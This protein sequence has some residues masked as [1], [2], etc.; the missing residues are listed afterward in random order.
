MSET[1]G[2]YKGPGGTPHESKLAQGSLLPSHRGHPESKQSQG[3]RAGR[4]EAR[5]SLL[6]SF[7]DHC[8]P[9]TVFRP[10]NV[11]DLSSERLILIL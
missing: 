1:E 3:T 7:P 11:L 5:D 9:L 4:A 10:S 2:R 6:P 8:D